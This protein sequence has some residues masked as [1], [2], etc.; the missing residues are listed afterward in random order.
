MGCWWD[1][2]RPFASGLTGQTARQLT[3]AYE[4]ASG[5][6]WTMTLGDRHAIIEVLVDV[7]KRADGSN[8]KSLR[9]AIK[10]TDYHSIVGPVNFGKGPFPNTCA[11]PQTTGQW[12]KGSRYPLDLVIV[13]NSRAPIVP[14][15]REPFLIQNA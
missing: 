1:P 5:K 10:T 3:D 4:A 2:S 13:D 15:G 7:L 9:D 14:L 6:Q 12:V 8:P 11:T